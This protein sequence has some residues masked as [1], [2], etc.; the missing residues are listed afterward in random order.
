MSYDDIMKQY[1]LDGQKT[2]DVASA[3]IDLAASVAAFS[4]R[5]VIA[6]G[7][8]LLE[9]VRALCLP[10]LWSDS[11]G[12][13]GRGSMKSSGGFDGSFPVT[14]IEPAPG[15]TKYLVVDGRHRV[16]AAQNLGLLH[17]KAKVLS[18]GI[19]KR[20]AFKVAHRTSVLL[21]RAVFLWMEGGRHSRTFWRSVMLD[22]NLA[23]DRFV[24]S[25]IYQQLEAVLGAFTMLANDQELLRKLAQPRATAGSGQIGKRT[26]AVKPTPALITQSVVSAWLSESGDQQWSRQNVGNYIQLLRCLLSEGDRKFGQVHLPDYVTKTHTQP[27]LMAIVQRGCDDPEAPVFKTWPSCASCMFMPCVCPS[28]L[29]RQYVSVIASRMGRSQAVQSVHVFECHDLVS[30]E[31][32]SHCD[33]R[34]KDQA[35]VNRG[36]RAH[37]FCAS[38]TQLCDSVATAEHGFGA[39]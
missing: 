7:V 33:G 1:A 17:V 30:G 14:L 21:G 12:S 37:A 36:R 24:K 11:P 23:R 4:L 13:V 3:E 19:P 25:T 2:I 32:F 8:A 5:S 9:Y 34:R 18:H 22:C 39:R 16:T 28:A 26:T 38:V 29:P 31:C 27:R 35:R 10:A 20:L 15:P 6:A